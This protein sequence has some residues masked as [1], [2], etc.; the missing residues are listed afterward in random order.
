[1]AELSIH[2]FIYE[3]WQSCWLHH[4]A[5]GREAYFLVANTK[6]KTVLMQELIR[7]RAIHIE[8]AASNLAAQRISGPLGCTRYNLVLTTS[9]WSD[10]TYGQQEFVWI[11]TCNSYKPYDSPLP[12][13]WG[14]SEPVY[15]LRGSYFRV[16]HCLWVGGACGKSNGGP[17]RATTIWEFSK[18]GVIYL[19]GVPLPRIIVFSYLYLPPPPPVYGNYHIL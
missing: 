10:Y 16:V 19:S 11:L 2:H 4:I 9:C 5:H 7:N 13:F 1:M 6:G 17:F 14:A 12:I 18:I 15:L 8:A 3:G